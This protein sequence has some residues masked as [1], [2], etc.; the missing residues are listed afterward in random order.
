MARRPV[1]TVATP[2]HGAWPR[3]T[4][5]STHRRKGCSTML[6]TQLQTAD[7]VGRTF[8]KPPMPWDS[9]V[10]IAVAAVGC[11]PTALVAWIA[12]AGAHPLV[13]LVL[14]AG[15]AAGMAAV[16]GCLGA[17]AAALLMWATDDGFVIHRFGV[18]GSDPRSASAL[19]VVM[20]AA[21]IAYGVAAL[22]RRVRRAGSQG[23]NR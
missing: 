23:T 2:A 11:A 14:F 17:M 3:C 8:D 13:G 9:E 15:V 19:G 16:S 10:S 21:V 18:L 1:K 20:G 5:M 6:M 7:P 4:L 22:V 12:G